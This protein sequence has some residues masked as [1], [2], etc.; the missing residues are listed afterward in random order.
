M[1]FCGNTSLERLMVNPNDDPH[2]SHY[3]DITMDT[4][5]PVFYVTC[6]CDTDWEWGFWYSKTNYESIKYIIMD[7]ILGCATMDELID[8]LDK[9][10]EEDCEY[11]I[12]DEDE[13]E[14]KD[15]ENDWDCNKDCENCNFIN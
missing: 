6:C 9:F 3:I 11:M 12:F 5:M 8:R 15:E 4:G 7:S 13:F 14:V 10:F 2:S 1:I